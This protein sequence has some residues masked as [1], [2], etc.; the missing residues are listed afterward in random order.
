M[1]K[2]EISAWS[3]D[4]QHKSFNF[5]SLRNFFLHEQW[6]LTLHFRHIYFACL[7]VSVE[8]LFVSNKRQNVWTDRAQI[9]CGTLHEPRKGLWMIKIKKLAPNKIRFS[10]NFEIPDFFLEKSANF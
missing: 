1:H 5:W 6:S 8:C 9:L 10:L 2:M 3:W 7:G 4:S